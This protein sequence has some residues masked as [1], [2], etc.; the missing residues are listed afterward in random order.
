MIT[1]SS[2]QSSELM[3]PI[4]RLDHNIKNKPKKITMKNSQL[5]KVIRD[6]LE[7]KQIRKKG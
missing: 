1:T 7:K 2:V 4:R 5:T 3:T 6:K